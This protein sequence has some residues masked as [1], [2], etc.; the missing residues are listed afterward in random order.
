MV[1]HIVLWRLKDSAQKA[2]HALLI[3]EKLEALRG[4]IP[5]LRKIEV[6]INLN[7]GDGCSDVCLYSEF[8][9]HDDLLAY[10]NHPLHVEA[11]VFIRSV[12]AERRC[13]DYDYEVKL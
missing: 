9:S 1:K 10:I 6:G 12:V 11:G 7:S 4:R 8:Y 2:E 13:V 5:S 3:K